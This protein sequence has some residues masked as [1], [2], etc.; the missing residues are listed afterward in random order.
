M[1]HLV[2]RTTVIKIN[3][4]NGSVSKIIS[5]VVSTG[6]KIASWIFLQ[7]IELFVRKNRSH[8]IGL[9]FYPLIIEFGDAKIKILAMKF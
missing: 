5:F 8:Q 2:T 7:N 3:S 4:P 1:Q 6:A 9:F